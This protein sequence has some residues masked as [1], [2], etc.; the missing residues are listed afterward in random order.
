MESPSNPL[1]RLNPIRFQC[2]SRFLRLPVGETT[3]FRLS[4]HIGKE[5]F[6]LPR[7]NDRWLRIAFESI[8][9]SLDECLLLNEVRIHQQVL[10]ESDIFNADGRTINKRYLTLRAIGQQWSSY[11]FGLQRPSHKSMT[12]WCKALRHLT[13]GGRRPQSLGDFQTTS[14]VVWNWRYD[15]QRD[16]LYHIH[17]SGPIQ[18]RK[19]ADVRRA[20]HSLY[21]P[22]GPC[23]ENMTSLSWCSTQA[24]QTPAVSLL[25]STSP[26]P[27]PPMPRHFHDLLSQWPN[28]RMWSNLRYTGDG[29]WLYKAIENNTLLCVADGSYI[30]EIHPNL[31]AAAVIIE[32]S[33]GGSRLS[34]SF[35][36]TS[37]VA[38]AYRGE[39]LGL[40]AIHLIL[41]SADRTRPGLS[42]TVNIY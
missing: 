24:S 7:K 13:P 21:S 36:D 1:A 2:H 3:Q 10:F 35:T 25:S 12:L 5:F 17:P 20:R 22:F 41:Y 39:L 19:V 11:R 4:L 15:P 31:C 29:Q 34:L 26:P 37:P 16:F 32:C 33:S 30:R 28:Q 27:P 9:Y 42:G 6:P 38:N 8:R 23:K 40:M 14:H 18:Y